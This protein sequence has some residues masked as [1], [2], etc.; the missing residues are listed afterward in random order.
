MIIVNHAFQEQTVLQASC[1]SYN[2]QR[3]CHC[4][5]LQDI[6]SAKL[7][8]QQHHILII[9]LKMSV[10]L[11]LENRNRIQYKTEQPQKRRH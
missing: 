3:Q 9:I 11:C 2:F 10:T 8:E 5:I 7:Q 1:T 4:K 6:S